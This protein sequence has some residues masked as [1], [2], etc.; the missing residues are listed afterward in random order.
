M[1]KK[2][3]SSSVI[4]TADSRNECR[5]TCGLAAQSLSYVK[6]FCCGYDYTN[7]NCTLSADSKTGQSGVYSGW[8]TIRGWFDYSADD[9]DGNDYGCA[10][11]TSACPDKKAA[12]KK[13]AANKEA[14]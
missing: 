9:F 2:C 3:D 5:E 10:P 6:S 12:A 14:A 1:N 11:Y 8:S 13:A 4:M 7:G